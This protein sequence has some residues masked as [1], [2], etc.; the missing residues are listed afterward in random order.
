M[1]VKRSER[2]VRWFRSSVGTGDFLHPGCHQKNGF[3]QNDCGNSNMTEFSK[4]LIVCLIAGAIYLCL[5][6]YLYFHPNSPRNK[7]ARNYETIRKIALELSLET[8]KDP[9]FFGVE[10]GT[11]T[12]PPG[13]LW[14]FGKVPNDLALERLKKVIDEPAL[15]VPVYWQIKIG[16]LEDYEK[17]R[18]IE[19]RRFE[20]RK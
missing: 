17:S 10:M 7:I 20:G 3:R 19:K 5:L 14:V 4:K 1:R 18:I 6:W 13:K 11:W 8:A 9:D 2:I 12:E 16:L 15:P